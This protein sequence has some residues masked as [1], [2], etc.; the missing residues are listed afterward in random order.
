MLVDCHVHAARRKSI[1]RASGT[2]YP[3]PREL[4]SKLDRE[5]IDKAVVMC[6]ISSE[7]RNQYVSP[8]DVLEMCAA[9]PDRL[10]PFCCV[11]PRSD[12]N[13]PNS[14]FSRYLGFY[15]EAGCKGVG[16][17]TAN[18][19]FDDPMVW[20]LFRYCQE[21]H[22]PVTFHIA[23]QFGGCYGLVDDLGL[24]RLER[25]LREFP[26]LIFLGHSQPF[27]AE[28]GA[29]ATDETRGGYPEGKVLPGG[30]VV[31]LMQE[32]DN[33]HG[34]LSAGSGYNAIS[35]DPEFG[36]EF[37]QRFQDRLLFGTD[38]SY[39]ELDTPIVGYLREAVERGRISREAYEKITWRNADRVLGLGLA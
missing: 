36:Y 14:D 11:D 23:P 5:G 30:R 34:D 20:N 13:S 1:P 33:L 10:I 26:D 27:W 2:Y 28:I 17:L 31:E 7:C 18:L 39:P 19:A 15:K 24:P 12:S 3:T 8:E 29:D 37:M 35:R 38:I 6:G 21:Y 9:H 22:M 25:A 16:E 4:V 32:Y